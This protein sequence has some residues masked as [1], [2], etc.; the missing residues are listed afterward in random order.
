MP[1]S[2]PTP[3]VHDQALY[4]GETTRNAQGTNP[5]FRLLGKHIDF[6]SCSVLDLFSI[7]L[8]VGSGPSGLCGEDSDVRF[9]DTE[10]GAGG[11]ELR[12]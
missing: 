11:L 8:R 3:K 10:V 6:P 12:Q 1:E 4:A 7:V 5:A 2:H 9:R